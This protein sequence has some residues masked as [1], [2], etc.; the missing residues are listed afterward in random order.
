[1]IKNDVTMCA[2]IFYYRE[3][4]SE[5]F[6]FLTIFGH[7]PGQARSTPACQ[8]LQIL[9]RRRGSGPAIGGLMGLDMGPDLGLVPESAVTRHQ[10]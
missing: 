7:P 8:Y 10:G 2:N 4:H 9:A 5:N 3:P 6:N 1:M